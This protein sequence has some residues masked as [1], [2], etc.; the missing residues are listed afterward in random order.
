M[1]APGLKTVSMMAGGMSSTKSVEV[2][3]SP[4]AAMPIA[5]VPR[6]APTARQTSGAWRQTPGVRGCSGERPLP[7]PRRQTERHARAGG[8][9][10]T[11]TA[12]PRTT[13]SG[14][15]PPC[16]APAPGWRCAG[17]LPQRGPSLSPDG[18]THP[19]RD[20][21]LSRK[22]LLTRCPD[23][24]PERQLRCP[25]ISGPSVP[26]SADFEQA[27]RPESKGSAPTVSTSKPG[28]AA[29]ITPSSSSPCKV[30][31]ACC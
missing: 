17:L 3:C 31:S 30:S 7:N 5:T 11:V 10:L 20:T 18:G 27:E 28:S 8:G 24:T 14:S 4:R 23:R 26:G 29:G 6:P 16:L 15:A 22:I 19:S 13:S 1:G 12:S 2:R 9:R 25:K 21:L